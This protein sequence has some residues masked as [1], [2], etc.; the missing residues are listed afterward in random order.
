MTTTIRILSESPNHHCCYQ[1]PVFV[2]IFVVKTIV[3]DVVARGI[4]V[5]VSS[6]LL[7]LLFGA[8]VDCRL[9]R[10]VASVFVTVRT[11]AEYF[12]QT[13][14]HEAHNSIRFLHLLKNSVT[15]R[16]MLIGSSFA[17]LGLLLILPCSHAAF[18]PPT[19]TMPTCSTSLYGASGGWG[20]GNARD[21]VPE[22]FAS[23]RGGDRKAFEGYRMTDTGEFMRKVKQEKDDL[24][25]QELD[26][27]LGVAKVAGINVKN[28][29]E[30]LNKFEPELMGD[31]DDDVDLS[32]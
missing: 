6:L 32:I 11:E 29:D 4:V 7:L 26:E 8:M 3:V 16:R 2:G 1:S 28:P 12:S 9:R 14:H 17:G 5:T 31:D 20:V 13:R 10:D 21:M 25:K 24:R 22:E 19:P 23:K 30:R 18:Q 15:M 27:L